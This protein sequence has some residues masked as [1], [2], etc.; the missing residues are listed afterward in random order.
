[1]TTGIPARLT[2][3]QPILKLGVVRIGN[4]AYWGSNASLL[5]VDTDNFCPKAKIEKGVYYRGVLNAI[6]HEDIFK[7]ALMQLKILNSQLQLFC[8]T[9]KVQPSSGAGLQQQAPVAIGHGNPF[10]YGSNRSPLT[11][12]PAQQQQI[13]SHGSSR[14]AVKSQQ[15]RSLLTRQAKNNNKSTA[16]QISSHQQEDEQ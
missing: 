11:A 16:V 5:G 13:S 10:S 3:P 9:F 15:R 4:G 2:K 14:A 12:T 8:R 7:L 6:D 1:M